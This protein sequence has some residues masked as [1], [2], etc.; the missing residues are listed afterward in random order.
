MTVVAKVIRGT[1]TQSAANATVTEVKSTGALQSAFQGLV[2]AYIR[3]ELNAN[4]FLIG[5]PAPGYV[6]MRLGGVQSGIELVNSHAIIGVAGQVTGS[7]DLIKEWYKP[8]IFP[9]LFD[10]EFVATLESEGSAVALAMS[11]TMYYGVS[12]Y[13]ELD[14]VLNIAMY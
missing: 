11:Y 2:V 14:M 5:S 12:T 6:T 1:I 9:P 10:E 8:D 3:L 13:S 7:V 4:L